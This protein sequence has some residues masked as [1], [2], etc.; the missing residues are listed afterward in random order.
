MGIMAKKLSRHFKVY[1]KHFDNLLVGVQS[2]DTLAAFLY[3]EG[4]ING[5][6]KQRVTDSFRPVVERSEV[7]LRTVGG[8]IM[9]SKDSIAKSKLLSLCTALE[10]SGE[11]ALGK[12]AADMRICITGKCPRPPLLG[13]MK[14]LNDLAYCRKRSWQAIDNLYARQ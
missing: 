4:L 13:I 1:Q 11:Q 8:A 7:M 9:T 5:E 2:T 12:I 3:A 14:S 10:K 6:T